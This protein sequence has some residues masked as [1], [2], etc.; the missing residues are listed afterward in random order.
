MNR[1]FWDAIWF[2]EFM[3][4]RRRRKRKKRHHGEDDSAVNL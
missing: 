4:K 3:N 1:E 2:F